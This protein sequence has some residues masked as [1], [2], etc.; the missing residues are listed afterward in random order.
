MDILNTKFNQEIDRVL[1]VLEQHDPTSEE[2]LAGAESLRTLC[3]AR[4]KKPGFPVEPEALMRLAGNLAGILLIL[5]Y[6]RLNVI[7]TRA[8][9]FIIK[10]KQ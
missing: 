3:D 5:Q 6:E 9:G 2:Y 4:A 10:P 1:G 7:S 8:L